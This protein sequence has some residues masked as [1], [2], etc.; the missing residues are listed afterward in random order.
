[1]S[2]PTNVNSLSDFAAETLYD[3]PVIMPLTDHYVL[4]YYSK[5]EVTKRAG[6]NAATH[7]TV[8]A[9]WI[10][11][12]DAPFAQLKVLRLQA[13]TFKKDELEQAVTAF[14]RKALAEIAERLERQLKKERRE[15]QV[16]IDERNQR[17]KIL[18]DE[19]P[20]ASIELLDPEDEA[21]KDQALAERIAE[22]HAR[23]ERLGG[24]VEFLSR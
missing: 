16:D 18:R 12:K 8:P 14:A 24:I 19:N 22:H 21:E 6:I 1:M 7:Q 23:E 4:G 9:L 5:L 17:A 11:E 2:T 3:F 10:G 20:G 13:D 15:L